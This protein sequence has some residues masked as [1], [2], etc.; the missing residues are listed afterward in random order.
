MRGVRV[1]D[2][3]GDDAGFGDGDADVGNGGD[4]AFLSVG[5]LGETIWYSI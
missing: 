1:G 4:G 2:E 3:L 5:D